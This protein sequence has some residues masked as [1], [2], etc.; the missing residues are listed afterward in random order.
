MRGLRFG[1][2]VVCFASFLTL[3]LGLLALVRVSDYRAK[4]SKEYSLTDKRFL[5]AVNNSVS[6]YMESLILPMF[7]AVTNEQSRYQPLVR[8]EDMVSMC[9]YYDYRSRQW[10]MWHE[11]RDFREGDY[12]RDMMIIM[13]TEGRAYCKKGD[14]VVILRPLRAAEA[15]P[16]PKGVAAS[17]REE[18]EETAE[19]L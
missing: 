7:V 9:V 18:G 11:G 6:N 8:Q 15:T 4:V 1:I 19:A 17:A 10:V 3:C 5:H 14:D 16:T 13:L 12:F 2:G